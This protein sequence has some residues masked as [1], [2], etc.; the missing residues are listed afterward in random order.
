MRRKTATV[1]DDIGLARENLQHAYWNVFYHEQ[2]FEKAHHKLG[3]VTALLA[4]AGLQL[5]PKRALAAYAND[6]DGADAD[7]W[8]PEGFAMN[9][10]GQ[11]LY[12]VEHHEEELAEGHHMIALSKTLIMRAGLER[13]I[14]FAAEEERAKKRLA[15][16]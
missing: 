13:E 5:D 9:L 14:P 12:D 16:R 15:K 3:L 1:E 11:A 2:E 4:R 6:E 7:M 8:S 10:L